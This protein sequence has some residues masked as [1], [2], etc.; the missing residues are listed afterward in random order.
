MKICVLNGSPKGKYSITLQTVLYLQNKYPSCNFEIL[1]V[2]QKIK[3]YEKDMKEA[4][5]AIDNAEMLLFC[6]PVYTFIAPYQLHRFIELLKASGVDLSDKFACQISTSKHFYD[7]TAHGY[8]RENC[9]DMGMKYLDGLSADMDDLLCEKGRADA[10]AFWDYILYCAENNLYKTL[11]DKEITAPTEYVASLAEAQK[12]NSFDTVIVTNCMQ[13][14]NSLLAMIADF[15]TAYPY[16]TRIVNIAEYPFAGGCLGCFNCAVNGKCIYRDNFDTFLREDIQSANAIVYAFTIKDHS[17]GASFKQYDDR[18]FCNGHRTVTMG[19]PMGYI[20]NGDYESEANLRLIIEGRC[21]VGHNFLAGCAT[22]K[23]GIVMLSKKLEYALE[24]KY[25]RPQNFLG[26]GGMK[27][28]RDLIYLMRGLM[29]ADHKFYKKHGIYDFPQKK[30]GTILK[31]QLLGLLVTNP[32]IKAK[33]GNKMN[34]G[35]IAPYKKVIE[36]EKNRDIE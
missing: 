35:M 18:Q 30:L 19:M 31:I 24:H 12:S 11:S 10:I 2:G 1:N 34:E 23:D 33:M 32:K 36:K 3:A 6:Y 13:N 28:F 21:E 16:K 20:I 27:I 22:D 9:L 4:L 29:K 25:T 26:V 17:M 14:D 7:V 5:D 8:I 15:Q